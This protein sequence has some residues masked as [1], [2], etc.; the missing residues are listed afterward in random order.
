[1]ALSRRKYRQ[2]LKTSVVFLFYRMSLR[3]RYFL[4]LPLIAVVYWDYSSGLL[5]SSVTCKNNE[6]VPEYQNWSRRASINSI[7]LHNV[8]CVSVYRIT[9]M[10]GIT[11]HYGFGN[12]TLLIRTKHRVIGRHICQKPGNPDHNIYLILAVTNSFAFGGF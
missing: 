9:F 8:F 2:Y 6:L 3:F 12:I 7:N 4:I 1:M 10:Y 5:S 11:P